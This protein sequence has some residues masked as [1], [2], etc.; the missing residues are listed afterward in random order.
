M[1]FVTLGTQKFQFDRLLKTV[2]HLVQEGAIQEEVF[3]QTGFSTYKPKHFKAERFL[4]SSEF[5]NR[6][7]QADIIISHAGVGTIMQCL[8][9]RKKIIVF[10]RDSQ[11]KEHVDRH[12]FEIA[13]YFAQKKYLLCAENA[14]ELRECILKINNVLL[15]KYEQSENKI[16]GI[17]DSYL[18]EKKKIKV[19]MVGSD[20]SVKGGIVSV[21]KNY[22]GYKGW[23]NS[24]ISFVATH[25]EGSAK[26]KIVFFLKGL[27]KVHQRLKK[28]SIDIVHIHVSERGS[29]IRKA[30]V[31]KLAKLHRCKVILH[32]HGAEFE[33]YYNQAKP[34]LKR[35][36]SNVLEAADVNIVLSERV[37]SV[38][39]NINPKA[40]VEVLYNAVHVKEE[41]QYQWSARDFTM[42]GRLEE[43]KGTFDFL[44]TIHAIDAKL[45]EDIKINLCG[46]G[47]LDKVKKA[48]KKLGLEHRIRHLGWIDDSQKQEI[49]QRTMCHVLFSYNEGLPMAILETM[50]FGIVNVSTNIASIP[51]V[52]LDGETGFLLE[53]GD[54]Q[55][56]ARILLEISTNG[57][58]RKEISE[59]SH[60]FILK[61]FSLERSIECLEEI[62]EQLMGL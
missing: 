54:K 13:R 48:I 20:L 41:N 25:I 11:Y 17:I 33:D 43:R 51:E 15:R 26:T 7:S 61:N 31:L 44:E 5:Q 8:K 18:N 28:D 39:R 57:V 58:L 56:L 9:M 22:L 36:I 45:F 47:D 32:H 1:I 23:K 42:L 55:G 16:M 29:F 38:I 49:M 12:Q 14:G 62:Y 53:P 3:A 40:N 4:N 19:L 30:F 27:L 21:L 50:A 2:D 34:W 24:D 35:Y 6:I 46:D 37:I 52:I 10:P 59:K 60:R